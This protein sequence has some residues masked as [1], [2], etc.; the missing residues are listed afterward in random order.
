MR[1]GKAATVDERVVYHRLNIAADTE[2]P[3]DGLR[4][5]GGNSVLPGNELRKTHYRGSACWTVE[6]AFEEITGVVVS[7]SRLREFRARR[8]VLRLLVVDLLLRRE[9]LYSVFIRRQI[10]TNT[11]WIVR[12]L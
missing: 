6:I 4:L 12:V 8:I 3:E 7:G 9:P 1:G 5:F 2:S 10:I 11:V